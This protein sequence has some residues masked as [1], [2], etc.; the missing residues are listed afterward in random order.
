M[1]ARRATSAS[2]LLGLPEVARSNSISF[3]HKHIF[4]EA[5]DVFVKEREASEESRGR[6]HLPKSRIM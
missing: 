2:S 5:K 1:D 3:F 4:R 6:Q